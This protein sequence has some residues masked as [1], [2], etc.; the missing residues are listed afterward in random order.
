MTKVTLYEWSTFV[1]PVKGASEEW[2]RRKVYRRL[3]TIPPRRT[4]S[5]INLGIKLGDLSPGN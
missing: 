2:L 3:G 1:V 4:A 5:M